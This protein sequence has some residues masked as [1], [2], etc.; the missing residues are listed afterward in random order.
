MKPEAIIEQAD[1]ETVELGDITKSPGF[2]LR[3]AQV[4]AFESFFEQVSGLGIKPGEFTVLWVISLNPGLKQ[5]TIART[6]HIKPAHM[7]KLVSRLAA[8]KLLERTT[9][10]TD[11]RAVRLALTD[12]GEDFVARNRSKFL[13]TD[14]A[15]RVALT[16]EEAETLNALLRKFTGLD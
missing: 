3:I 11:R 5:G 13:D 2:L 6:L 10:A 4:K 14:L 16:A 7:T 15:Q 8:E 1:D 9:D 12:K